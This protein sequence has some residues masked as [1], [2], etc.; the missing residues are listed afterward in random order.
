M[1]KNIIQN[2]SNYIKPLISSKGS[3]SLGCYIS[4]NP[5]IVHIDEILNFFG[6]DFKKIEF[7]A[8]YYNY[9]KNYNLFVNK[10]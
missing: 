4:K 1:T 6:S 7:P 3:I 2:Y 8:F 9:Q 5:K 10:K